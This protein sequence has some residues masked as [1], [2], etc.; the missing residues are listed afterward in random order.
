MK[1]NIKSVRFTITPEI[2]EY[3]AKK[4]SSIE[5]LVDPGDESVMCNVVL[6][7]TTTHH[8]TGDVFEAEFNLH[9]A[10]RYLNAAAQKD[11]PKAALDAAKD[12]LVREFKAY[13]GKKAT[14][15]RKIG[16]KIKRLLKGLS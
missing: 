4:V 12:E 8:K 14:L 16:A 9:V 10:G 2:S 11:T 5:K 1:T 13:K 15:V 7:Q 3:I 6:S